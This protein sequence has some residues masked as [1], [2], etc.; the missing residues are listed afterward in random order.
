MM[1]EEP[2]RLSDP[3]IT[4]GE[5]DMVE[6]TLC[7][8][9]LSQGRMVEA[10]EDGFANWVGRRH[11]VAV[12]GSTLALWLCL[13]AWEIQGED[14]VIAS[15]HSWHQIARG[16]SLAGAKPVFADIDY[17]AGT[18]APD[19]AMEKITANTRAILAG[20]TN[21]H[22]ADW[23]ALRALARQ[24]HLK[25]IEDCTESIGSRYAGQKAGTFGDCAIFDFSQPSAL[26]SGEGA[27]IVT[28]DTDFARTLRYLRDRQPEQRYSISI[29]RLLPL[30][31]RIS[32]LTAALGIVQLRRI[33]EILAKR[34]QVAEW[35][36]DQIKS[37]E[38]IKP[39]YLAPDVDEVN[40]FL[41]TVH[42]GTR[43]T[44][45][46]SRAI[47]EDMHTAG[48]EAEL[49]SHP[50]YLERYYIEQGWRKGS[51]FVTEKVADRAIALPF[52]AHL[53]EEQIKFIVKTAKD[54]SV[55][56]GAGA[57]IYL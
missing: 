7:S 45:S 42:L 10:F 29:S 19:K 5:L 8:P 14:E 16:I 22:P 23:N 25:L 2:I 54:A 46:S 11:A 3:D 20:N 9:R 4:S 37:F 53:T 38:G 56:V 47:V 27:M 52:H 28:D 21:G 6:A 31:A 41:Y 26:C 57:A 48:I 34:K 39:P 51:C 35:Y 55:N 50:L 43:F 49:Y 12:S 40:W 13:A 1:E 17:W 44:L 33:E 15:G 18:L 32:E 36:E 24:H 30:N